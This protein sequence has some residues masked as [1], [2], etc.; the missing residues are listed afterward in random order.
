MA[1]NLEMG[2]FISQKLPRVI[3][4]VVVG[5]FHFAGAAIL[6]DVAGFRERVFPLGR[7]GT[8]GRLG[9]WPK[10]MR[11]FRENRRLHNCRKFGDGLFH[12]FILW[13]GSGLRR[14]RATYQCRA[15]SP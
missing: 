4:L 15:K 10:L 6:T 13:L 7:L 11:R 9:N 8:D 14:T 3:S 1:A 2:F 12:V 5:R